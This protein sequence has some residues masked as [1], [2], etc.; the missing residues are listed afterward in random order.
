MGQAEGKRWA[1]VKYPH[2]VGDTRRE[3][4]KR[5]TDW[6][7]AHAGQTLSRDSFLFILQKSLKQSAS[8][9][10]RSRNC[11]EFLYNIIRAQKDGSITMATGL[12]NLAYGTIE[13]R[14]ESELLKNYICTA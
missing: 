11:T 13:Q 14:A 7:Q 2:S 12:A 9:P 4:A 1:I 8:A 3:G 6:E 10:L 5:I